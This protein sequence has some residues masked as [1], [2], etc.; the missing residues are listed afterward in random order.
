MSSAL[1]MAEVEVD[2]VVAG[3]EVVVAG[4]EADVA[5]VVEAAGLVTAFGEVAEL[6]AKTTE[7]VAPRSANVLSRFV[8]LMVVDLVETPCYASS[9]R[10]EI[11]APFLLV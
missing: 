2:V 6:W 7:A 1:G 4:L 11:N 9:P 8:G 3:L 5:V 10:F